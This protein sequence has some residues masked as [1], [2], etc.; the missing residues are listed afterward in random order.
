MTVPAL[1]VLGV[2]KWFGANH[3]NRAVSFAVAKGTIHGIVGENGA[4][5]STIMNIV[6]GTLAA[7]A[8]TVLV[9]GREA[10]ISSPRDAIA[11]GI[12]MVHQHFMLVETFTALENVLLGFEGGPTLAPG[13]AR[14]R[15]ELERLARDYA[16]EVDLDRP[17]G[18]LAVGAQQRVEILKALHHGADLLILDEPTGVLTPQETAHL[19]RILRALKAQGKTVIIIT[20]KL[21][22]IVE[23][24]DAVTVMRRGQV[25]ATLPTA[26]TDAAALAEL[27]VGRPVLLRVDKTP[28]TPGAPVLEVT[29]LRVAERVNG[30]DF[31]VRSGEIVGIAGVSGNGQSELL[32]AL[33]GMR[34]AASGTVRLHG[35]GMGHVPEDRQKIGLV[36]GFAAFENAVLGRQ[37]DPALSRGGLLFDWSAARARCAQAMDAYDIRPADPDLRTSGFSGGN[38]QKLVL[39]R[40]I[41]GNPDLLLVGQPTRGVDI[42]A[43]EFIHRR[44]VALRDSGTAILLVSA[45]L[46][47][48]RGLADRILV[49]FAGRIVGEVSPDTDER[50]LGLMMAGVDPKG[51]SPLTQ[52]S[53]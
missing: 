23:L 6:Y 8:G 7:D 14:A 48:I 40:E 38:Q 36:T 17:V 34:P 47:E 21:R 24:T 30:V 20:H 3:A 13:L 33:A 53:A 50:T 44:L 1:E 51:E 35:H 49:M 45:E 28:A 22:E 26:R 5:K 42:G 25:V 43:I 15:A 18:D 11:L 29:D 52:R 46:D 31:T 32:E 10:R 9:D 27:M 19:F 37:T 39:A 12:G 41:E 4:G 2:E 16:L